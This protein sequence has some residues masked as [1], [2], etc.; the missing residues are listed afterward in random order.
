MERRICDVGETWVSMAGSLQAQSSRLFVLGRA[1]QTVGGRV[2]S[3][4]RWPAYTWRAVARTRYLPKRVHSVYGRPSGRWR[5]NARQRSGEMGGQN[6]TRWTISSRL[7]FQILITQ[8]GHQYRTSDHLE[9]SP[10]H[11]RDTFILFSLDRS[12]TNRLQD[13]LLYDKLDDLRMI[14]SKYDWNEDERIISGKQSQLAVLSIFV[15]LSSFP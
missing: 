11:F 2:A 10:R 13:K 1:P 4:K 8:S 12:K 14:V 7:E 9:A 15:S 3:E 6:R 5:A